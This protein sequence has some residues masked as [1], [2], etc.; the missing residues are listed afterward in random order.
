MIFESLFE[1]GIIE[2]DLFEKLKKMSGLRNV[3]AH[4]YDSLVIEEIYDNY[5][6]RLCYR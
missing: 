2:E 6:N 4:V 1:E 3:I 5:D